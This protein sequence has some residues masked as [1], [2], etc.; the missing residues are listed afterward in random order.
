VKSVMPVLIRN[1]DSYPRGNK[2]N[3]ATNSVTLALAIVLIY[4]IRRQ[5]FPHSILLEYF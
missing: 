3:L 5:V 2:L 1:S 4:L